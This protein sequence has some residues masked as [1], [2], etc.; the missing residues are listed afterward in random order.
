M[1]AIRFIYNILYCSLQKIYPLHA[2]VE[3][4]L[5]SLFGIS[6]CE[7]V[8]IG[9]M[10]TKLSFKVCAIAT[11]FTL[12]LGSCKPETAPAPQQE[13]NVEESLETPVQYPIVS[14]IYGAMYSIKLTRIYKGEEIKSEIASAVFYENPSIT[15]NTQD[16]APA[17]YVAV[18]NIN[19]NQV[20][21]GYDRVATEGHIIEH[22]DY[23]NGVTWYVQGDDGIPPT[24]FSWTSKFPVYS[25][26]FPAV[27]DRRQ[28]LNFTFNLTTLT[29]ADSVYV[30]LS[31]G[32]KLIVRRY[33][34]DAGKVK[35]PSSELMGL[36]SCPADKP[37]YLQISPS[38]VDI[39]NLSGRPTVLVKQHTEIRT[40][41]IR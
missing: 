38:I 27:I 2:C 37:G 6:D 31:A 18:N 10:N 15:T 1:T 33:S 20:A 25:G 19:L 35:I 8:K 11:V 24:T 26:Y 39:F 22:L 29:D 21:G 36:Q 40:V 32:Q 12:L 17:G 4:I 41:I 16:A 23:D 7:R 28:D 14:D 9:N 3:D 13:V 5:L 30:A 34:Y